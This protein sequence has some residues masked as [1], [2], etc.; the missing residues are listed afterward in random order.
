MAYQA[1][2]DIHYS[3]PKFHRRIFANLIDFLLFVF[4]FV[5]LF[6]ASRAIVTNVPGYVSQD[7]AL[8][9]IR[10]ESG[11]YHVD[12]R[13]STDIV[14][15]L[16]DESN[17]YTSYQKMELSAKAIDNF[18]AYVGSVASL[19]DSDKV[20][21]D[22]DK[23]RLDASLSY[24]GTSYFT[25]NEENEIIRNKDCKADNETYFKNAYAPFIDKQCLGYLVTLVP[26]YLEIL[27][28]ESY[29][30]FFVEIPIAFLLSGFMTYL[31]P[32]IFFKRGRM[33]LGKAMYQIGLVDSRL[34]SCT[35]AR[36]FAR[37]SVFF[38]AELCLS[39]FTFGL[40]CLISFTLMICSKNKQGF[41]DYILGLY[42]V[43]LSHDKIY[44]SYEEISLE[45]IVGEKEPIDFHP[46]YED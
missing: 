40:P 9:T 45:G 19:E 35:F 24:E 31:L 44:R 30:L 3:S 1:H 14:S 10:K 21:E 27:K 22:Y 5:L 2:Y 33:T 38:F 15:Y 18:I 25:K 28:F 36:Y 17:Q 4:L 46:N 42:E 6:L 32:P 43:D 34:L 23:Y 26:E 11:L 7:N 39:I 12:G 8:L 29:M 20:Q 41:P 37:W 13:S 16:D